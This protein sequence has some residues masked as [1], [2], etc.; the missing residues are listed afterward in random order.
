MQSPV[1]P[2]VMKKPLAVVND[3][4]ERV[5]EDIKTGDKPTKPKLT[6]M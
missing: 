4:R 2:R 3:E 5:H 1:T 6:C